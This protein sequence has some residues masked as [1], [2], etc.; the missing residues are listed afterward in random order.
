MERAIG[1]EPTSEAWGASNRNLKALELA[2]LS[3]SD[4]PQIE[5]KRKMKLPAGHITFG[6]PKRWSGV[7]VEPLG[8]IDSTKQQN[9]E[10]PQKSRS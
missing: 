3:E 8:G 5:N 7:R 10:K 2:A 1:I 4:G 6:G 9:L